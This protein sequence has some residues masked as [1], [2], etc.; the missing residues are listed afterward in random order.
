MDAT[1]RKVQQEQI[2]RHL[3]L[4]VHASHCNRS[5][6]STSCR[7]MKA[8]LTHGRTCKKGVEKDCNICRRMWALLQVHARSCTRPETGSKM[9]MV[10]KCCYLRRKFRQRQAQHDEA[11]LIAARQRQ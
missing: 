2:K 5:C 7:K 4:L 8:L 11:R 3:K 1:S 9:C 6:P 10:L